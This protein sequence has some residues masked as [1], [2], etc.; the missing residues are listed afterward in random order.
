MTKQ[1]KLKSKYKKYY[2]ST[3]EALKIEKAE[4]REYKKQPPK[5][6][7]VRKP[8]LI[9]KLIE[10]NKAKF[11]FQTILTILIVFIGILGIVTSITIVI[12]KRLE[13]VRLNKEYKEVQEINT[14]LKSQISQNIDLKEIER[15]ATSKLGMTTPK[16]HQIIYITIPKQNYGVMH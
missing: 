6:R 12:S 7:K 16:P 14:T 9:Y 1:S 8:K 4:K 15:I 13:I 5:K 3:S 10:D 2:S 11:S